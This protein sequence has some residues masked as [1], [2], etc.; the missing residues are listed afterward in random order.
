MRTK[1]LTVLIGCAIAI[2]TITAFTTINQQQGPKP[3]NLKVLPKN[4]SNEELEKTMK[5]FNVALG[6]KCG[7]CHAPKANGE[8]GLDFA[9]DSKKE[10]DIA[11]SMMRMTKKI[12]KQYFKYRNEAGALKQIDCETC[13]N[14][15]PE[16]KIVLR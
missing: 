15:K 6:V 5:A 1:Q 13:H 2:I 14:G 16:A 10:K 4:I 9:S 8:K 11:R 12:N 3:T 7:H